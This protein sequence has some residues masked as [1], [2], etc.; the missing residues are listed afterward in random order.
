MNSRILGIPGKLEAQIISIDDTHHLYWHAFP[1]YRDL[2]PIIAETC[3]MSFGSALCPGVTGSMI[4][5]PGT[6]DS[7]RYLSTSIYDHKINDVIRSFE[8]LQSLPI[9]FDDQDYIWKS[10]DTQAVRFAAPI[11][12]L[13]L[14][15]RYNVVGL[16]VEDVAPEYRASTFHDT[17]RGDT[18]NLT[19]GNEFYIRP[20]EMY[21]PINSSGVIEDNYDVGD[22]RRTF[23]GFLRLLKAITL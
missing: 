19:I 7:A 23:H 18:Y 15:R 8:D 14:Y 9:T 21:L 2:S 17:V 22:A 5:G 13:I 4:R 20:T 10:I 1:M 11:F 6:M 3:L 16:I 12:S